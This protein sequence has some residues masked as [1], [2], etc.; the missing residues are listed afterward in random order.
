MDVAEIRLRDVAQDAIYI[1]TRSGNVYRLSHEEGVLTLRSGRVPW[2]QTRFS[3]GE[4]IVG[5]F[6]K[7]RRIRWTDMSSTEITRIVR[8]KPEETDPVVDR[9]NTLIAA[10]SPT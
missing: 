5:A 6:R 4:T 1:E 3:E 8:L 2:F 9:F 10:G 7:G